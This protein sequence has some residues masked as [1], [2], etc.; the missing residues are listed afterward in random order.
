MNTINQEKDKKQLTIA[1]IIAGIAATLIVITLLI[2]FIIGI[3]IEKDNYKLNH[4]YDDWCATQYYD[5]DFD[6]NFNYDNF[7]SAQF[8]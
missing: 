8:Y 1:F 5:S 7:D 4:Q 3:K 2:F 6:Y